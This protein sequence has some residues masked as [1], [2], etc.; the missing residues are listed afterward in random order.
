MAIKLTMLDD[1]GFKANEITLEHPVHMSNVEQ[2][3]YI[4]DAINCA[5]IK[6][7]EI[8]DESM[9]SFVD[10]VNNTDYFPEDD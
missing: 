5:F 8:C 3:Q 1:C 6:A 10:E 4:V 9:K 2:L 7:E